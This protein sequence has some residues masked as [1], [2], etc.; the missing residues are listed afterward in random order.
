VITDMAKLMHRCQP[1]EDDPAPNVHMTTER[2]AVRENHII[3]HDAIVTNVRICHEQAI[4]SN[5]RS[6]GLGCCPIECDELADDGV[7]ADFKSRG[8][9]FEFEVLRKTTDGCHRMDPALPPDAAAAV[10]HSVRSDRRPFTDG[11]II[12]DHSKWANLHAIAN[13]GFGAHDCTR[14]NVNRHYFEE[15]FLLVVESW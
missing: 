4:A 2:R 12:L 14:I 7:V 1:A 6:A 5:D 15:G 13:R 9:S 11:D 8:L 10:N 3:A